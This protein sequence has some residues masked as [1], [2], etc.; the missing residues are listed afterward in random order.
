[1]RAPAVLLAPLLVLAL[2]AGPLGAGASTTTTVARGPVS[3]LTGL[4]DPTGLAQRRCA[5][6]VKID[7]TPEAH[8]Q[9]GLDQ[10]D[11]V[12]EEI[13]EGG[14]TRLAAVFNSSAPARVGPVRSVR[15]TDR[16]IVTSLGGVFVFSGGAAYA[17]ASI[18]TAPVTLV[19]EANAGTAMYRDARRPAP[20]NLFANVHALM[21]RCGRPRPPH[22]QFTYG[23]APAGLLGPTVSRAVVGF[24]NG[25]ATTWTWDGR[26]QSWDRSIFSHPDREATGQLVSP[27]NVLVLSVHY[28]GGVGVEGSEAVLTGSGPLLVLTHH[29]V[30][31]GHWSRRSLSAPLS[32]RS[33]GGRVIPLA[34]G[35]TW[36]ELLDVS[37]RVS[38]SR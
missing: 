16:E 8:P 28:R 9:Y 15:R 37:E 10:A 35:R 5:V 34:P 12:V 29:H 22:L 7:N 19:D 20:H 30:V 32:L 4:P 17:L 1:M 36:V 6:T 26:S 38:L 23:V 31:H 24:A 18:A 3:P 27:A 14:I 25:Y 21:G 11:L 13:V 2:A 33:Q